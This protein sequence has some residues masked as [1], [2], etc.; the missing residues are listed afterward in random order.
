MPFK[1]LHLS[2]IHFGTKSHYGEGPVQ[3]LNLMI[4]VGDALKRAGC[5]PTLKHLNLKPYF[6]AAVL[7]GDFTWQGNDDGFRQTRQFIKML[8][9]SNYCSPESVLLVP[10]NHDMSFV[11]DGRNH[12]LEPDVERSY[13][14][15][16]SQIRSNGASRF[17]DSIMEFGS[18]GVV[19]AG[20]NSSRIIRQDSEELGFIGYDQLFAVM[21]RLWE[22]RP[23]KSGKKELLIFVVHHHLSH[24]DSIDAG[25]TLPPRWRRR[26][27]QTV[28][29]PAVLEGM[30]EM[31]AQIVL[32]GHQHKRWI[33][34]NQSGTPG[35]NSGALPDPVLICAAGSAG[36][37]YPDSR[38][39]HHF[40]VFEISDD[41]LSVTLHHFWAD[42]QQGLG[43]PWEHKAMDPLPLRDCSPCLPGPDRL[44]VMKGHSMWW[45]DFYQ[46]Q[47]AD[48]HA[49]ELWNGSEQ[50]FRALRDRLMTLRHDGQARAGVMLPPKAQDGQV[51]GA[52]IDAGITELRKQL[53]AV[54]AKFESQ[55]ETPNALSVDQFILRWLIEPER[56]D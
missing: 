21:N 5:Q 27:S 38:D 45:A 8:G 13:R 41:L 9:D 11:R 26:Q 53:P 23:R 29:A 47:E 36:I 37:C 52:V 32:H 40:Q 39:E 25:T 42:A 15:F 2:D 46:R 44:A 7:S 50:E 14:Q 30:R 48:W 20:L 10:G 22:D 28:D 56:Y 3:Y 4:E 33:D 51:F 17:L 24:M 34:R 6:Q 43:R 18:E 35:S 54:R 19:L 12:W 31:N 49:K 16:I 55:C 1:I